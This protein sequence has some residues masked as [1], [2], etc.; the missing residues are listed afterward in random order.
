MTIADSNRHLHHEMRYVT[1]PQRL[2]DRTIDYCPDKRFNWE[3][4]DKA[5]PS[6]VRPV[7][8]KNKFRVLRYFNGKSGDFSQH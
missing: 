6:S 7:S 3:A 1:N 8:L 5:T 4:F 2:F